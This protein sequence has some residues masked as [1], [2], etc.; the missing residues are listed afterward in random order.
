MSPPFISPTSSPPIHPVRPGALTATLNS[1]NGIARGLS[2]PDVGSILNIFSFTANSSRA[3]T[4]IGF[5]GTFIA[6][7]DNIA[8]FNESTDSIIHLPSF[9]ITFTNAISIV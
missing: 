7:N 1:S 5:S 4:A 6:F 2:A 9:N 3:F 8:G